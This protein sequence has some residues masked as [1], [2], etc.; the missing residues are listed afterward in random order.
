MKVIIHF[1]MLRD[2][3]ELWHA[4]H[5]LWNGETV[6]CLWDGIWLDV[7]PFMLITTEIWDG[8]TISYDKSCAAI[9]LVELVMTS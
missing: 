4:Q 2:I 9:C 7:R 6:T 3:W 1:T 8:Q 5:K